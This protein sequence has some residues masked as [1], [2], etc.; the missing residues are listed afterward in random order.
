MKTTVIYTPVT[1]GEVFL[2]Y[3]QTELSEAELWTGVT[4]N[5]FGN[6]PSGCRF[7]DC[8]AGIIRRSGYTD[9]T[10]ISREIG[11][12]RTALQYTIVT[13][14]GLTP[15]AW[16]DWWLLT[17]ICHMLEK[18]DWPIKKIAQKLNFTSQIVLTTYFTKHKKI[19]P[20]EWRFRNASG[21]CEG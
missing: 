17:T 15:K 2:P 7:I 1:P 11:V 12:N 9:V 10:R 18:T 14:T 4:R 8:F 21:K 19:P 16:I 3:F 13:L 6:R 5:E 20:T